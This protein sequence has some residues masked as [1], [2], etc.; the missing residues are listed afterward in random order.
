MKTRASMKAVTIAR[1]I[2]AHTVVHQ[3]SSIVSESEIESV[4]ARM[5]ALRNSASSP[6]TRASAP[7]ER[8]AAAVP[9]RSR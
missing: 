4:I 3:K 8:T 7:R 5:S 2:A 6:R 9:R 1:M